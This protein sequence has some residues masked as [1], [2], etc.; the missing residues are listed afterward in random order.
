M[1]R[2]LHRL[3]VPMRLESTSVPYPRDSDIRCERVVGYR[4]VSPEGLDTSL[5]RGPQETKP[6]LTKEV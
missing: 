6:C 5:E 3:P 1:K 4:D 2:L